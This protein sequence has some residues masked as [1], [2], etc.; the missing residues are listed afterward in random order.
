MFLLEPKDLYNWTT[1][2]MHPL[3]HVIWVNQTKL[4]SPTNYIIVFYV[5]RSDD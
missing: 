3:H 2:R 5:P 1:E 4:V